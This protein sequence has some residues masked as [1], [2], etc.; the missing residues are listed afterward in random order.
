[1][2]DSS[3]KNQGTDSSRIKFSNIFESIDVTKRRT[4]IIC[5]L[6]PACGEVDML[7]K[8]I[9]AGLRN[10]GGVGDAT[11]PISYDQNEK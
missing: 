8:M 5:T 7:V 6:G 1:M 2:A 9:D 10:G 4:K 11:T 3:N